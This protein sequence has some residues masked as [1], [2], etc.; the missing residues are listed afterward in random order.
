[1][2]LKG[3]ADAAAGF[4]AD[5][6]HQPGGPAYLR[7]LAVLRSYTLARIFV[8]VSEDI[9]GDQHANE[10]LVFHGSPFPPR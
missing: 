4:G 1:M 9:N 3:A 5:Q 8:S 7:R 2:Q 6:R 10:A